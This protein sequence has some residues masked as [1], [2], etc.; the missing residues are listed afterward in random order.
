[1]HRNAAAIDATD[2]AIDRQWRFVA[3]T[4]RNICD[5]KLIVARSSVIQN[6]VLC[7]DER[8]TAL[9]KPRGGAM[10][11]WKKVVSPTASQRC[12]AGLLQSTRLRGVPHPF[13]SP[14]LRTPETVH[15]AKAANKYGCNTARTGLFKAM[16]SIL[17][18]RIEWNVN[19]QF[20]CS[21]FL[22][23][24]VDKRKRPAI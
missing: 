8:R 24:G 17:T 14:R 5:G 21:E 23:R 20:F 15:T 6:R 22:Q 19:R 2:F 7:A 1:L 9:L 10:R 13:R 12:R 4:Y 18:G 3:K 16:A 11:E